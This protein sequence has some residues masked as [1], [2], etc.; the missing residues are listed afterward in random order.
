MK[1]RDERELLKIIEKGQLSESLLR[2]LKDTLEEIRFELYTNWTREDNVE[3]W[4]DIKSQVEVINMLL[5][6]LNSDINYSTMAKEELE[7]NSLTLDN[8]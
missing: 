8:E 5:N 6:K 2:H 3:K 4:K 1:I 7:G